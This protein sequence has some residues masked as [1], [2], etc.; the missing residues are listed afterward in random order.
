M[1][2][3]NN[4]LSDLVI[5]NNSYIFCQGGGIYCS[6]GIKQIYTGVKFQVHDYCKK[7]K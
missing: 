2:R 6:V 4:M 3:I 7:E 1:Q 5:A